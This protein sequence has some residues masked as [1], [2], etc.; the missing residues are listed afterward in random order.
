VRYDLNDLRLFL[1]V[2]EEGSITAGARRLH[3]SLSSA[4]ARVR[5][6]EQQAGVDLLVR[7]RRGVRPTPAG[8]TLQRHAR[9]VLTQTAKLE[10]AVASYTRPRKAALRLLAGGSPMHRL[11]LAALISFLTQHADVDVHVRESHTPDTVR[12][13]RNGE[14]DLGVLVDQ[15]VKDCGLLLE[16]LGDDSLVAIGQRGGVLAGRDTVAFREVAEHPMVGLSAGTSLH[17]WIETHLGPQAPEVRYRTTA[18]DLGVLSTLAAAGVGLAVVPR[19]EV[20]PGQ[21]LD[22]C[23]LQDAWAR[24]IHLLAWGVTDG[25]PSADVEALAAHLR[26][27]AEW[28]GD[29]I[30]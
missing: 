18:P 15:E 26:Q 19:R 20:D 22:V 16:P 21:E 1:S 13:L 3:L 10:S 9:E 12:M 11:V 28:Q 5:Q 14:A 7:E 24:R 2:V 17:R 25:P 23:V 30:L 6:L 4:S 29:A 27:A 8:A